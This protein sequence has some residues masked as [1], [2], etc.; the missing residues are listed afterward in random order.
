MLALTC[1]IKAAVCLQTFSILILPGFT[2]GRKIF[3][4][5]DIDLGF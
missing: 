4:A 5:T 2:T 1:L 3:G